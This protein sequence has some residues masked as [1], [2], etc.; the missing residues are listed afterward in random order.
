MNKYSQGKIYKI[1]DNTNH[2]V[3]YGSTIQTL[4]ER[5]TQ[6][7]SSNRCVS[8]LIINNNNYNIILVENYPCNSVEELESREAHYIIN[9]DCINI[10]IPGRTHQQW[11]EDNRDKSNSYKK[12]WRE[13]NKEKNRELQ[14]KYANNNRDKINNRAKERREYQNTWGGRIDQQNNSLLKIDV[15]LFF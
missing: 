8:R 3:Y 2:D 12:K 14:K 10:T 15:N 5:L 4:A 6:H 11:C 1:I 13:N 9:N 7:K